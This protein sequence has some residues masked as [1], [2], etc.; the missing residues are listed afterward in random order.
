MNLSIG[1]S[2]VKTVQLSAYLIIIRSR[3]FYSGWLPLTSNWHRRRHRHLSLCA[4]G[5]RLLASRG[6]RCLG[7]RR[8]PT[9]SDSTVRPTAVTP[10]SALPPTRRPPWAMAAYFS[11][12]PSLPPLSNVCESRTDRPRERAA[13]GIGRT[14]RLY[15]RASGLQFHRAISPARSL[16]RSIAVSPFLSFFLSPRCQATRF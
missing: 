8:V 11:F 14:T 12:L 16:G 1:W 2:N 9:L 5:S 6:R 15:P 13:A 7:R 10:S 3:D 4:R